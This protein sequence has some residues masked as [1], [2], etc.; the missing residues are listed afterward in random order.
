MRKI[1]YG[2][3][4]S[5][6]GLQKK[7]ER[8]GTLRHSSWSNTRQELQGSLKS[9]EGTGRT[10]GANGMLIGFFASSFESSGEPTAWGLSDEFNLHRIEKRH[11]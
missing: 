9:G 5:K 3:K 6:P 8:G 10:G 2:G 7:A 1:A 11:L 4:G